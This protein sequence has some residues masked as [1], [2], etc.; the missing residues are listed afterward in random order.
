MTF[1]CIKYEG[2]C[3]NSCHETSIIL[4]TKFLKMNENTIKNLTKSHEI[5]VAIIRQMTMDLIAED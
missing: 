3:A 4:T 1:F 5:T 2:S